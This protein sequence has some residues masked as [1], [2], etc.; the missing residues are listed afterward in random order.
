[1]NSIAVVNMVVIL[2]IV[3][4]PRTYIIRTSHQNLLFSDP[5]GPDKILKYAMMYIS[6][7]GTVDI[8]ENQRP[9][10]KDQCGRMN[11]IPVVAIICSPSKAETIF[12]KSRMDNDFLTGLQSTKHTFMGLISSSKSLAKDFDSGSSIYSAFNVFILCD[13]NP[14]FTK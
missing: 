10:G 8:I 4:K 9:I 14:S 3:L 7:V 13:A 11:T 5:Q 6:A 12:V 2:R 1:M